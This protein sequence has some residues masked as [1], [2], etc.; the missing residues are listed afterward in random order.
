MNLWAVILAA[1]QGSRLAQ[2][3]VD[4]KKQ[5]LTYHG[6]PLFWNSALTFARLPKITGLIFV[7]PE[8]EFLTAQEIVVDLDAEDGL[9]LPW[10]AVVGGKRRQDSVQRGLVALPDVCTHVLIHDSA[11]PFFSPALAKNII[12][13]LEES[14]AVIP[15]L[16]VTDT[17]KKVDGDTVTET[18]K[19][20][21]LR[22]V[23]TPQG[24]KLDLLFEA[25]AFAN[26]NQLDVTDD[27]SMVEAI[28]GAVRIVTGEESNVKITTPAD[29][30]LLDPET[31][32]SAK[33]PAAP[34][35]TVPRVGWG[36][37]VHRF[38]KPDEKDSREF[39]LGGVPIP[40]GPCIKAHSDGD[41][42]LHALADALLGCFCGGDIGALF[43]DNDPQFDNISSAILLNEVLEKMYKAGFEPVHA[44]LTII[45]QIPKIAPWR[46]PIRK[47]VAT[48]LRISPEQVNIKATTEEKLGFTGEKKGIKAVAVVTAVPRIEN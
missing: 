11:R 25:H 1:G 28:D 20:T 8:K 48:L 7:F 24:F 44:D 27:A 34:V 32:A 12:D 21:E 26:D 13:A 41:V 2:A 47:S 15:A 14:D 38:T 29:L 6:K 37:D 35:V 31:A 5:F 17:I 36:Y 18:L 40:K 43:P 10:L 9:G 39:R 42:L 45:T 4:A 30:A 22:A 16:P 3:G 33:Q 23:Q 19:R 46:D